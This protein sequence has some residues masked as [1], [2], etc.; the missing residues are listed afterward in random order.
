MAK[1]PTIKREVA[2]TFALES[3][4]Q[5]DFYATSDAVTEFEKFGAIDPSGRGLADHYTIR[6]DARYD[7][8]EVLDYIKAY[9]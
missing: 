1:K 8:N 7:F 2:V 9:D 4:G 3:V 5:I 6:V